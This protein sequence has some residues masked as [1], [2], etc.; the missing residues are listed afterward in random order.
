[1][2]KPLQIPEHEVVSKIKTCARFN[3]K[4]GKTRAA[5]PA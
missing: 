4:A 2:S 3:K 1:V 5:L